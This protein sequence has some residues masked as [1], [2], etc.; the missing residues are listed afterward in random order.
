MILRAPRWRAGESGA[1]RRIPP[2]PNHSFPSLTAGKSRGSAADAMMCSTVMV[3]DL[4]SLC[5]RS[6]WW[7]SEPSTQ[8][9]DCPVE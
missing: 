9:T 3:A 4:A 2:S 1:V 7:I 6:H 5:G 8:V